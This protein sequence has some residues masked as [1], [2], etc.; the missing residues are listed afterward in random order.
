[1]AVRAQTRWFLSIAGV[2]VMATAVVVQVHL[3]G[4]SSYVVRDGD[5]LS[6]VA[7][8]L[9]VSVQELANANGITDPDFIV[10][11]K[12][13]VVPADGGSATEYL[14][15]NGD[16]LTSISTAVGVPV[17]DL[18]RANGLEDINW[19]PADRLLAIP[20]VGS[21]VVADAPSEVLSSGVGSYRVRDGD[22]LSDIAIRLSVPLG[23][24]AA[25]NGVADPNLIT[26]GQVISAPNVWECPVPAASFVNDYGYV[27][28]D[29]HVHAGVDLFASTGTPVYA[30]VGG[31]VEP[32]PNPSGGDAIQLY[33]NDGN[34]YY[35]AHLDEYGETGS[36]GAGS[37]VGYVGNSGDAVATSPHL[38][39]EIHP[40]GGATINPF[41]TL[42]AACR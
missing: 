23:Q 15:R 33:G 29:G 11:G 5:T 27:R 38:H 41:P 3:A 2:V 6:E 4:A 18:A 21:S 34:R 31:T 25:A 20:P 1:V 8:R 36:V 42:I 37:V 12:M 17:A 35:F 22:S 32:F 16:T 28:P 7:E 13:L 19:V 24:L 30:P 10:A 26:V 14:V 40:G 39:F 9:G